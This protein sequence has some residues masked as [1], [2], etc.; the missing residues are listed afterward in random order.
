MSSTRAK[1]KP[2][3]ASGARRTARFALAFLALCLLS[4]CGPKAYPLAASPLAEQP[5]PLNRVLTARTGQSLLRG[6]GLLAYPAFAPRAAA[7]LSAPGGSVSLDPEHPW[8]ALLALEDGTLILESGDVPLRR[9]HRLGLRADRSGTVVGNRPW[10]DL[11]TKGRVGQPDWAGPRHLFR[12]ASPFAAD[13]FSFDVIYAGQGERGG[14]FDCLDARTDGAGGY[15]RREAAAGER[16]GLHGLAV[17]VVEVLPD[18][19]RYR[20]ETAR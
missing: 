5:A 19:V 7:T 12:P 11:A 18:R 14:V 1:S 10:F 20:V 8:L 13:A 16:I 9:G 3:G 6:A 15:A 17:V 4:A 2:I